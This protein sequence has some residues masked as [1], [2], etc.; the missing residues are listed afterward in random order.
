MKEFLSYLRG[1]LDTKSGNG[2]SARKLTAFAVMVLVVMLHFW[3]FRYQY[4]HDGKFELTIEI[5]IIDY[6]FMALLLGL[7]TFESILKLKN[8]IT[9]KEQK[10]NDT[11]HTDAS[12]DLTS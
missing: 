12:S 4:K 9:D 3:Y 5:L 11:N 1:S 10:Q 8:G 7:T 6:L 2:A